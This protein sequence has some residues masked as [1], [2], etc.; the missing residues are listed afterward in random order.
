M[1]KI[2]G[3]SRASTSFL[4]LLFAAGLLIGAIVTFYITFQEMAEMR[5][6]VDALQSQLSNLSFIQNATYQNITIYQN[7]SAL[8]DIYENVRESVVLVQGTTSEGVVQGSGFIYESSG[9]MWSEDEFFV[10]YPVLI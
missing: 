5:D 9:R 10:E 8:A 6:D 1:K 7:V 4:A 3:S 2:I